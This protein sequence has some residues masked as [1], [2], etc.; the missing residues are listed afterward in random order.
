MMKNAENAE[1]SRS[2]RNTLWV[3]SAG[4]FENADITQNA[5][6]SLTVLG[7]LTMHPLYA[8]ADSLTG[9]VIGAAI[10][11]Q[12]YFGLG[13]L[14]SIYVKCLERELNLMGLTTC[15]EIPVR[16]EYK[17]MEGANK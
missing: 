1:I 11:V 7:V 4:V 14:E 15:R 16:V 2:S 8:K 17:G 3:E 12:R 6:S 9:K 5:R 10:E 13:L